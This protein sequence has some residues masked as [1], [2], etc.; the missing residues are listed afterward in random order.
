MLEDSHLVVAVADPTNNQILESLQF[1][2]GKRIELAVA[3]QE[4]ILLAIATY[5]SQQDIDSAL[6]TIEVLPASDSSQADA[7]NI[8]DRLLERPVVQLVQN[9][10][11]EAVINRASDIHIRPHQNSIELFFRIDGMLVHQRSINKQLLPPLLL[12]ILGVWI[13]L[14]DVCRKMVVHGCVMPTKKSTYAY[15]SCRVFTVKIPL[16]VCSTANLP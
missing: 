5:Y 14:N 7:N 10:I 12:K 8:N 3:M 13:F 9:L 1:I 6:K 11:T 16:S 4:D 2:T 15:R